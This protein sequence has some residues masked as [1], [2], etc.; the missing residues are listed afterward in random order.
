MFYAASKMLTE[1]N[2]VA[3]QSIKT[4]LRLRK[5][6]LILFVFKLSFLHRNNYYLFTLN[7][8]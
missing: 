6:I 5:I 3:C 7:R 2:L 1:E 4:C 8:I